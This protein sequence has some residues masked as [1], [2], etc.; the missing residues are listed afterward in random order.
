MDVLAPS[1]NTT[2]STQGGGSMAKIVSLDDEE[3]PLKKVFTIS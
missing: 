2:L 1:H 3:E